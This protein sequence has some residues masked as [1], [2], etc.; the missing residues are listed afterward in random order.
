MKFVLTSEMQWLPLA[1]WPVTSAQSCHCQARLPLSSLAACSWKQPMDC[2]CWFYVEAVVVIYYNGVG[3]NYQLFCISISVHP[4]TKTNP[5]SGS[6]YWMKRIRC[7][8][9]C[10]YILASCVTGVFSMVAGYVFHVAFLW[11]SRTQRS[12]SNP[13]IYETKAWHTYMKCNGYVNVNMYGNIKKLFFA[14][15]L[16]T[17]MLWW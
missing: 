8:C 6:F 12:I 3:R 11:M 5:F 14:C 7:V 9:V 17:I 10:I 1:R 4:R 2:Y 15:F 13:N 16:Y